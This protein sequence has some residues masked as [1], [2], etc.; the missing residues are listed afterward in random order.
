MYRATG[1]FKTTSL[2]ISH[3]IR[4]FTRK[5]EKKATEKKVMDAL[6]YSAM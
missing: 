5:I 2:S 3:S 6:N 1:A 4:L